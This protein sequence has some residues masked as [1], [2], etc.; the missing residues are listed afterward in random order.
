MAMDPHAIMR[1]MTPSQQHFWPP[2]TSRCRRPFSAARPRHHQFA[3]QRPRSHASDN[4]HPHASRLQ[5][6]V[7]S[8]GAS[9][10]GA[11]QNGATSA[12]QPL[13][14]DEE[15]SETQ[16]GLRL[17]AACDSTAIRVPFHMQS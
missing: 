1:T 2:H 16:V 11:L 5:N 9:A 14:G 17:E 13:A 4:G 15:V 7:D 12:A 6:G 3:T 10:N 8:N